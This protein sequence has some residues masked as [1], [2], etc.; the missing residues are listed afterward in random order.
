MGKELLHI[1]L[2]LSRMS[3]REECEPSVARALRQIALDLMLITG[4]IAEQEARRE[5]KEPA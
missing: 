5:Q 4:H 2:A 1:A 3:F